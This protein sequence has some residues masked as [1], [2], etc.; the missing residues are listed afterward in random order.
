MIKIETGSSIFLI[1][2]SDIELGIREIRKRSGIPVQSNGIYR[3]YDKNGTLLYIGMGGK[4]LNRVFVHMRGKSPNTSG[5]YHEI[6]WAE[7]HTLPLY[8]RSKTEELEQF[9]IKMLNPKYNELK[10]SGYTIMNM[11]KYFEI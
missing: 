8:R 10:W 1:E 7:I 9:L 4:I 5:Y 11:I 3:L 6:E 2:K